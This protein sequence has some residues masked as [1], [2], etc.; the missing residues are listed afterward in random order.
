MRK[1]TK[2]YQNQK[3]SCSAYQARKNQIKTL[4][5]TLEQ[6]LI[7]Q[8]SGIKTKKTFPYFYLW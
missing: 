5:T 2:A 6:D 3:L 8:A 7:I 1:L 4:V